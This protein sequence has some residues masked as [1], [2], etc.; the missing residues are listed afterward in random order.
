MTIAFLINQTHKEEQNCTTSILA[1]E[2]LSRG[3]TV[4]YIGIGDFFMSSDKTVWAYTRRITPETAV[5]NIDAMTYP[6]S[7]SR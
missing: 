4:W 5:K 6:Q 1:F 3:H 2:A 7:A